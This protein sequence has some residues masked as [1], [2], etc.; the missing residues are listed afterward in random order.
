LHAA[1]IELGNLVSVE[2]DE[3]DLSFACFSQPGTPPTRTPGPPDKL[4]YSVGHLSLGLVDLRS[5]R[6]QRVATIGPVVTSFGRLTCPVWA[7]DGRS[8]VYVEM[9]QGS[10][11]WTLVKVEWGD[12]PPG[13]PTAIHRSMHKLT[14]EALIV[15]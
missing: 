7:K 12:G 3:T 4:V 1:T 2:L 13:P 9:D 11:Q 8:F 6:A 15:R 14:V 5:A 10:P